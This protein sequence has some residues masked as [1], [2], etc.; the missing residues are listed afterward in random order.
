VPLRGAKV[1]RST[2]FRNVTAALEARQFR[3]GAPGVSACPGFYFYS[4][5]GYRVQICAD[6]TLQIQRP[7]GRTTREHLPKIADAIFVLD[8][9]E[10]DILFGEN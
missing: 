1:R 9:L 10:G 8:A 3:R 2:W 5:D 4:R 6:T 7:S